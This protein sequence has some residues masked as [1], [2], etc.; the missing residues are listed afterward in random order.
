MIKKFLVAMVAAAFSLG[1]YA[2]AAKSDT[3]PKSDT[4]KSAPA[5]KGTDIQAQKGSKSDSMKADE[6]GKK[7]RKAKAKAK[8]KKAD[9][10]A[11]TT[12]TTKTD[13]KKAATK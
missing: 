3:A 5:T 11:T 4:A 9:A 6:K 2:Q 7:A 8:S 10:K 12:T 13:E 1:A